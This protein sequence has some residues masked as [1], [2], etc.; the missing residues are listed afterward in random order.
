[1]ENF[2]EIEKRCKKLTGKNRKLTLEWNAGAVYCTMEL[3]LDGHPIVGL[4]KEVEEVIDYISDV[5][6]Y[7]PVA[8]NFSLKGSLRYDPETGGLHGTE[9]YRNEVTHETGSR[10]ISIDLK[11]QRIDIKTG[12]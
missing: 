4:I 12:E 8:G 10:I 5:I 11:S 1:M 2:I 6:G 7:E 3:F 9:S